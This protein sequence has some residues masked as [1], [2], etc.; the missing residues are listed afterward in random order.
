MTVNPLQIK[1]RAKKLGVLIADA[2]IAAGKQIAECARAIGVQPS[3]FENY[4]LGQE[5]PSLPELELL[6]NYLLIPLDHFWENSSLL[7]IDRS[8]QGIEIDNQI[9]T[10]NVV[11]AGSLHRL[12]S[13]SET[14]LEDAAGQL[15]LEVDQLVAFESGETSVPLPILEAL[16]N[17]YAASL[18]DYYD[19]S[20]LPG[21]LDDQ[22]RLVQEYM[23]L[24][25]ALRTFV[26]MPVNRPY[27]EMA[28]KLSNMS[29]EKLRAVAEV[30]L[31]ITL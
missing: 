8:A 24:P 17:I 19:K 16:T 18:V 23:Q 9:A 30:L 14:S 22:D 26:A 29:V 2:R 21:N 5:A 28:Q 15:G 7:S 1:L 31:E 12:R 20:S 27:L 4:E 6:A 13:E 10:R 11:I 25:P 3:E